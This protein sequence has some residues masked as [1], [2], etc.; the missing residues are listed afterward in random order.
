MEHIVQQTIPKAVVNNPDV[1]WNPYT[2]SV[3]VSNVRDHD[4]PKADI[5]P[6]AD[7]EPDTRYEMLLGTFRALKRADPYSPTTPT[8][9]RAVFDDGRELPEARVRGMSRSRCSL[10][11]GS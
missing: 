1:D 5:A 7:R 6:S 11:L 3:R 9:I 8:H 4:L 2:K 10:R